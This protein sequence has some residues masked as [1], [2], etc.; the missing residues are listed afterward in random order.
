MSPERAGA[1]F[2]ELV[3]RNR[4]F[5]IGYVPLDKKVSPENFLQHTRGSIGRLLKNVYRDAPPAI[6]AFLPAKRNTITCNTW[7]FTS[8]AIRVRAGVSLRSR[9]HAKQHKAQ[10]QTEHYALHA[11]E[12]LQFGQ[13][14]Q[15]F[16]E[17]LFKKLALTRALQAAHLK[18]R[19]NSTYS[20]LR[21]K[22]RLQSVV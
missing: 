19:M 16:W 7:R 12:V 3:G 4:V 8:E 21:K 5:L 20:Q 15:V 11:G 10:N 9:Q 13:K 2:D 1:I 17:N 22:R 18:R 6:R 14:L